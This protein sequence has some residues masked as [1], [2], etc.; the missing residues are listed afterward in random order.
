MARYDAYGAQDN[1]LAE[2]LDQGFIGFNNKLRPDQLRPG[3][4]TESNNGRMDLNGEWQP[5]KGIEVFSTPLL[6]LF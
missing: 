2:D 3:M 4:L 6:P 1:R 5:R